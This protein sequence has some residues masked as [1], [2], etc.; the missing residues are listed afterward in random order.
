[1]QR[2]VLQCTSPPRTVNDVRAC[3]Q[4]TCRGKWKTSWVPK[5]PCSPCGCGCNSQHGRKLDP[6]CFT[7]RLVHQF[8]SLTVHVRVNS[9]L[10]SLRRHNVDAS[11]QDHKYATEST[12]DSSLCEHRKAAGMS[13]PLPSS[14]GDAAPAPGGA[15]SVN[16]LSKKLRSVLSRSRDLFKHAN[17]VLAASAERL[18]L[19]QSPA[20]GRTCTPPSSAHADRAR[21]SATTLALLDVV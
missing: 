17:A 4:A 12:T 18:V 16:L 6:A 11:T 8:D 5:S 14:A 20:T 7:G 9:C 1:M 19:W 15:P 2:S 21:I 13:T 10:A 3:C